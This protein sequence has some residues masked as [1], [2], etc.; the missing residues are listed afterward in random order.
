M[1]LVCPSNCYANNSNKYLTTATIKV[2]FQNEQETDGR[3]RERGER[4]VMGMVHREDEMFRYD[5]DTEHILEEASLVYMLLI[6]TY[7]YN[8]R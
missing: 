8:C 1:E 6:V 3:E 5:F 4:E 2:S 7:A